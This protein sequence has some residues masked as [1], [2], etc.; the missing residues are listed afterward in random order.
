[1]A[2]G[3]QSWGTVI[4]WDSTFFAQITSV[5]WGGVE[6]LAIETTHLGTTTSKTFTPDDLYD[7]GTVD[8]EFY[9]DP[10]LSP[11]IDATGTSSVVVNWSGLGTGNIW[12]S[13]TS[14]MTNFQA[15]AAMGELMTASATIKCNGAIAVS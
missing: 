14:F 9:F 6:R 7:A 12:T 10:T 1:M 5:T 3:A 15:G 4:T 2:A 11:S 13:T 8:V